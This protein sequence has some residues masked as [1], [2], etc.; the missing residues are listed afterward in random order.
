MLRAGLHC[1][2]MTFAATIGRSTLS[3]IAVSHGN[4]R[5]IALLRPA[6]A[7][8]NSKEAR[9]LLTPIDIARALDMCT[10]PD[11]IGVSFLAQQHLMSK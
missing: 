3:L 6:A 9:I 1:F 4:E 10:V 5:R 8:P 7:A 2:D 11:S